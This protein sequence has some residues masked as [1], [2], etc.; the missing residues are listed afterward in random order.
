MA[1][2]SVLEVIQEAA[3]LPNSIEKT[4]PLLWQFWEITHRGLKQM[5][6]HWPKECHPTWSAL[7]RLTS[8]VN[9]L[10]LFIDLQN[11]LVVQV[12]HFLEQLSHCESQLME[13]LRWHFKCVYF[14]MCCGNLHQYRRTEQSVDL[15]GHDSHIHSPL[16]VGNARQCNLF[17]VKCNVF[18]LGFPLHVNWCMNDVN[19]SSAAL[20]PRWL[21]I[22]WA[23]TT[24]LSNPS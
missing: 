17:L 13:S 6:S 22:L 18:Q 15:G 9:V 8:L 4:T 16:Q 24:R 14:A 5:P 11:G 23:Q 12:V 10:H 20:Q 7:A 1:N 3:P 19:T 2:I 21:Y